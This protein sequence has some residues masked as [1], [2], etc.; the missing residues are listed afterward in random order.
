LFDEVLVGAKIENHDD[1]DASR[2]QPFGNSC[3]NPPVAGFPGTGG[4][5]FYA[6]TKM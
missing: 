1:A 2:A 6:G 5:S 4:G 3:G